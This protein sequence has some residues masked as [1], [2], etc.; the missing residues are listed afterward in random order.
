M[1]FPTKEC[2]AGLSWPKRADGRLEREIARMK[3]RPGV[4]GVAFLIS[5]SELAGQQQFLECVSRS[6]VLPGRP[7]AP[8]LL[9]MRQFPS[10]KLPAWASD[11][12]GFSGTERAE[13]IE[14]LTARVV[15]EPKKQALALLLAN[16]TLLPAASNR[17]YATSSLCIAP[18]PN[19][20]SSRGS[21]YRLI[22]MVADYEDT[23]ELSPN[24]IH[25]IGSAEYENLM[26]LPPLRAITEVDLA[27]WLERNAVVEERR[28]AIVRDVMKDKA[29][30]SPSIVFDRLSRQAFQFEGRIE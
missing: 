15:F 28:P 22:A 7:A 25:P 5:G 27:Q 13:T 11:Q 4:P 18:W 3:I 21:K 8:V 30:V 6:R 1:Y 26:L 24:L 20:A 23:P 12:F 29:S 19:S 9:P 14:D 10:A 16:V 2:V 17:L